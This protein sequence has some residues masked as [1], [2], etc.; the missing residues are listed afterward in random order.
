MKYFN[1]TEKNIKYYEKKKCETKRKKE[2]GKNKKR[3]KRQIWD[4][5]GN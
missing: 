2:K 4:E 5:V 3:K 1:E